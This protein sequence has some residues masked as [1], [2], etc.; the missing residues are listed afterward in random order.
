MWGQK[1]LQLVH[2]H[3]WQQL[4]KDDCQGAS[5]KV[6]VVD[7]FGGRELEA[8]YGMPLLD[9]VALALNNQLRSSID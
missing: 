3:L 1:Y 4:L 9:I 7:E 5:K 8:T 2:M 6:G